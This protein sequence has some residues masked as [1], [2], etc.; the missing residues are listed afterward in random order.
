MSSGLIYVAT[1]KVTGDQYV[2]LTTRGLPYRWKQHCYTASRNAKTYFH[3]AIQK[4]GA[5]QFDVCEYVYA[6]SRSVL[7]ALE[8]DVILQLAPTY[9][10]TNGGEIT[11]GRKY[12]DWAIERIRKSNTGKKRTAEQNLKNS[13]ARKQYFIDHPEARAA[14]AHH[15]AHIRDK[16][17]NRSKQ[18]IATSKASKERVWSAE[19]RAKLSASTQGRRY[20]PEVI[21]K[22]VATKRKPVQCSDGRVFTSTAEAAKHTGISVKTIWRWCNR[23][24]ARSNSGLTFSYEVLK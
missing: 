16:P 6:Q 12:D 21:A 10:Q 7:A 9:N 20:G 3:R 19:S 11:F 8:R 14:N 4:Y 15:L 18:K 2:G 5:D 22:I 1:N 24:T 23:K 17:E 13:I